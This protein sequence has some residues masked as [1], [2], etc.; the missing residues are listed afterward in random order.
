MAGPV[1]WLIRV[2]AAKESSCSFFGGCSVQGLTHT[3][4]LSEPGL[5]EEV[6]P[7][8]VC[9]AHLDPDNHLGVARPGPSKGCGRLVDLWTALAVEGGIYLG[10]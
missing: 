2:A 1:D 9:W 5:E 8:L 6:S 3:L 10:G 7:T 4:P